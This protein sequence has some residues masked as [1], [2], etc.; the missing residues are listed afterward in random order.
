MGGCSLESCAF[1]AGDVKAVLEVPELRVNRTT[2][3]SVR[4][5]RCLLSSFEVLVGMRVR[6]PQR[7]LQLMRR[8]NVIAVPRG[9]VV[10]GGDDVPREQEMNRDRRRSWRQR[11]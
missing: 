8:P 11:G 7:D 10:V 1:R 3:L 6:L 9:D 4:G 5:K 2:T